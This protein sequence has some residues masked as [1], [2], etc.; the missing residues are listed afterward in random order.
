MPVVKRTCG[1][2]IGGVLF[3]SMLVSGKDVSTIETNCLMDKGA[4]VI[5]S[6]TAEICKTYTLQKGMNYSISGYNVYEKDEFCIDK[7][8]MN[9]EKMDNL[10]KLDQIAFLEEG[11]NDNKAKAFERQLILK[12]RGIVTA[13]EFQPEIFP[14]ACEALQFEYEKED[15]SYLEIEINS[16]DT[17]EVFEITRDGEEKYSMIEANKEAIIKVVNRFYG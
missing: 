10:K 9:E 5:H 6:S 17:W 12:A 4:N 15:G 3:V 2:A 14:T 7:V 8:V 11:W 1:T 13:L 16:E